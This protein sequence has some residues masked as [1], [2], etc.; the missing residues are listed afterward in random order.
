MRAAIALWNVVGKTLYGFLVTFVPLH[1][2]F[3][4][5]AVFFA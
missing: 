5:H 2:T 4:G 3:Y 1:R